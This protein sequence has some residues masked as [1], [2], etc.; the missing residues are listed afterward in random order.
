MKYLEINVIAS[1]EFDPLKLFQS[2]TYST[3][4]IKY[5][6]TRSKKSINYLFKI[7][8]LVLQRIRMKIKFLV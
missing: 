5:F 8:I 4:N 1:F 2:S 3:N 6:Y 7:N